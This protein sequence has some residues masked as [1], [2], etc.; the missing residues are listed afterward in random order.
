MP[1]LLEPQRN[2]FE[3][4]LTAAQKRLK[5]FAGKNG[6]EAFIKESFV[7]RAEIF[8]N[9]NNFD[10]AFLKLHGED[11]STKLPKTVSAALEKKIFIAVSP[12]LYRQNY[13][14]GIEEKSF[15][16]LIT[17]EMA[18]RL[19]IR[20]LNGDEHAM[21]PIWFFEGFAIYAAGQ[22]EKSQAKLNSTEIWEIIKEQERGS[23]KN[24]SFVFRYFLTRVSINDLVERAGKKDFLDWLR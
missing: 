7:D 20:I 1:A 17:H 14:E 10:Q 3:R 12:K 18:H 13:P 21:G 9:K 15:E 16:K 23:Y 5:D 2:E 24:Y 11:P 6:W 19:H 22:F 4:T 8:D